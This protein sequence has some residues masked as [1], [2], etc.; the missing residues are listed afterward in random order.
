LLEHYRRLGGEMFEA[1]SEGLEQNRLRAGRQGD[2]LLCEESYPHTQAHGV[3]FPRPLPWLFVVHSGEIALDLDNASKEL[4]FEAQGDGP[5]VCLTTSLTVDLTVMQ[6]A[7]TLTRVQLPATCRWKPRGSSRCV[8]ADLSLLVPMARTAFAAAAHPPAPEVAKGLTDNLFR[9][10]SEQLVIAGV[11]LSQELD[12]ITQL[13]EYVQVAAE[14]DLNLADLA[15]A[16]SI[17]ARRLQELTKEKFNLTPMELLRR[18]RLKLLHR[19]IRDP[20]QQG[21]PLGTLLRRLHLSD[22]SKTR[23]AFRAEYG[24]L[25]SEVRRLSQYSDRVA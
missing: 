11:Q 13:I 9:Y 23:E 10:I 25:P 16:A 2:L 12:P 3:R 15:R 21:V 7:T 6:P 19:Y 22:T 5:N 1:S 18:E 4:F 20:R 24:A 17:S 8:R 14:Q